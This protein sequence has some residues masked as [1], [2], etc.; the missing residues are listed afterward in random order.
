MKRKL[1]ALENWYIFEK[2]LILW[3]KKRIYK[4]TVQKK[5]KSNNQGCHGGTC[6]PNPG[7]KEA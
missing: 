4:S 2:K 7:T 3:K 5:K 1:S 6:F